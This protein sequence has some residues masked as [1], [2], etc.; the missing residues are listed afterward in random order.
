MS[1][2]FYLKDWHGKEKE[3]TDEKIFVRGEDGELIQ[4]TQGEGASPDLRYVT[5]M[6]YDGLT[7]Y[8]KKA[9]AVG[10]D[11]ADPIARGVFA[12]PTRESDVQYNYTFYGWA[13]T[14]NGAADSNWNK[15][16]TEDKVVYAN[17]ASAVR[18]Y[19][20]TYYDGTTVLKTESLAYG[21]MPSYSPTKDG[22]TFD[23]WTP[24]LAVVTGNASYT[25]KWAEKPS[26]AGST[27]AKIAEISE[28]GKAAEYF[29]I[30]D[31]KTFDLTVSDGTVYTATVAIADFDH[32]D[33]ADGSGKAGMTI[34]CRVTPDVKVGG[35][36]VQYAAWD[37][38]K[39]LSAMLP[40]DLVS[41]IKTVTKKKFAS[42]SGG[43]GEVSG[44]FTCFCYSAR[45]LQIFTQSD[46][47]TPYPLFATQE[48]RTVKN[49]ATNE[50]V[51]Y[52]TRNRHTTHTSSYASI[53]ANG[54]SVDYGSSSAT[55]H[56]KFGFCI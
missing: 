29:S 52:W 7:E 36:D 49:V 50:N 6:S 21:A 22:V 38:F 23:S 14:A 40:A 55:K 31:T 53:S 16:I 15:A 24:S 2:K 35:L 28:S 5:F 42:T 27:W 10:D 37:Y 51:T 18:Y 3:F 46:Y 32:D 48:N 17:F 30:G 9:V 25:A 45:E 12:T 34:D 11:C 44:N 39:N 41:V 33:L 4:F 56:A 19:T 13:T 8:G 20:I 54:G 26:F 43:F 47:G 1:K